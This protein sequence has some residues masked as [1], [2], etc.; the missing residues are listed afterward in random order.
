MS[1]LKIT[2]TVMD[3]TPYQVQH[4][5][6]YEV[7]KALEPFKDSTRLTP[8]LKG[9]LKEMD[10]WITKEENKMRIC[11]R[12]PTEQYKNEVWQWSIYSFSEKPT[13]ADLYADMSKYFES[14][15]GWDH[16]KRSLYLGRLTNEISDV[17]GNYEMTPSQFYDVRDRMA[18]VLQ[19]ITTAVANMEPEGISV[20]LDEG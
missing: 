17:F 8:K 3:K 1:F 13:F 14:D 5:R 12:T 6:A 16:T 10:A 4:E 9:V 19:K 20:D 15:K 18:V 2:P 11:V 7:F